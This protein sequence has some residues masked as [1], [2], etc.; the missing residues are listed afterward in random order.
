MFNHIDDVIRTW[1][2]KKTQWKGDL[3]FAVKSAWKKLSK[4]YAEVTPTLGMLLL[5]AHILAAFQKL[6]SF[7]K[8]DKGMDIKHDDKPSYT[9][10]SPAAILRQVENEYC[11]K[12]QYVPV[13]NLDSSPCSNRILSATAAGSW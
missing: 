3:F 11:A 7:R 12:H 10:Q 5:S 8:W 13:Y 4:Y 2:R 9:T 1:E 6:P